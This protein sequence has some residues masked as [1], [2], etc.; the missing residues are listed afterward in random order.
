MAERRRGERVSS[1]PRR[2]LHFPDPLSAFGGTAGSGGACAE[3]AAS[4]TSARRARPVSS[5]SPRVTP[6][7][8]QPR[9]GRAPARAHAPGPAPVRHR[10][11]SD[12]QAAPDVSGRSRAPRC[13]EWSFGLRRGA[14]PS[15]W[16]GLARP[17]ERRRRS[18]GGEHA[19]LTHWR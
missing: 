6:S 4:L 5:P 7:P 13:A 8:P 15:G 10:M 14:E 16:A 18:S 2:G 1:P 9:P 3:A 11:A 17:A 19:L 12:T